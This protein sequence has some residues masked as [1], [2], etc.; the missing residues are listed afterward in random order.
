MT[1][2]AASLTR[3]SSDHGLSFSPSHADAEGK[4]RF[5]KLDLDTKY[6]VSAEGEGYGV[7]QNNVENP[8]ADGAREAA[9]TLRTP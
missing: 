4:V 7:S 6:S 3:W 8:P 5:E 9:V 2:A 1:N